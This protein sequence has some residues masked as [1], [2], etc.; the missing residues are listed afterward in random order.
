MVWVKTPR[1]EAWAC[2][3]CA[4]AF[5]PSGPPVGGSLE[6]MMRNYE[7]QRG[8]EYAS[9]VCAECPKGKSERDVSAVSRQTG[10]RTF[11]INRA[12]F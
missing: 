7:L 4:W 8:N 10:D 11:D 12:I 6:E 5:I 9:H 1:M 2:S 3:A